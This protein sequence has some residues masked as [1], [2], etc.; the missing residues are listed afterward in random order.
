MAVHNQWSRISGVR[1]EH[2]G[3]VA[4]E[5]VILDANVPACNHAGT[6]TPSYPFS[7]FLPPPPPSFRFRRTKSNL[8]SRQCRFLWMQELYIHLRNKGAFSLGALRMHICLLRVPSNCGCIHTG[9]TGKIVGA[10]GFVFYGR[11][12]FLFLLSI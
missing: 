9:M 6:T 7:L 11:C 2:F 4:G 5:H 12:E 8:V 10:L 1:V 3:D